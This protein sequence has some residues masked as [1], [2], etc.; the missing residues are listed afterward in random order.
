MN[1]SRA[2][3]SIYWFITIAAGAEASPLV[4]VGNGTPTSWTEAMADGSVSAVTGPLTA[5]ASEYFAQQ[6][7]A[8]GANGFMQEIPILTPDFSVSDGSSERTAL[9]MSWDQPVAPNTL[10]VSGWMFVYHADPDLMDLTLVLEALAPVG[11][12]DLGVELVDTSGLA[13]AWFTD[14]PE[15]GV[16]DAGYGLDL[17]LSAPQGQFTTFIADPGFDITQVASLRF[18]EASNSSIAFP[19]PDPTGNGTAWNAW[20]HMAVLPGPMACLPFLLQAPR[21][22]RRRRLGGNA[23]RRQ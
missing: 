17:S 18:D 3:A 1:V 4:S 5:P 15:L 19:V 8:E 12:Q 7:V 2:L 6:V 14:S 10:G 16:W 21:L 13:E 11:V 20:S 22:R 9:V 23:V